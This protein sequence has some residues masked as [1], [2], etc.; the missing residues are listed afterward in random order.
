LAIALVA[1][2]LGSI[3]NRAHMWDWAHLLG[4]KETTTGGLD[5]S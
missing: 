4:A 1:A 2:V 3:G 5:R